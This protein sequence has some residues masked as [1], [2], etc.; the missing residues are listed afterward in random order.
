MHE[1]QSTGFWLRGRGVEGES[2][3]K[4]HY[5]N[6]SNLGPPSQ[7]INHLIGWSRS[8][9]LLEIKDTVDAY[10]PETSDW[11]WQLSCGYHASKI[12]EQITSLCRQIRVCV[13]PRISDSLIKTQ[14]IKLVL[15]NPRRQ[16]KCLVLGRFLCKIRMWK[17]VI[18]KYVSC[19]NPFKQLVNKVYFI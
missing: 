12:F 16:N 11:Y 5:K 2:V 8:P 6:L 14:N 4:I 9:R 18:K 13:T 17:P 3:L 10:T 7:E 19:D 15:P 1:P